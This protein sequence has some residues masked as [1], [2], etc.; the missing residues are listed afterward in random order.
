MVWNIDLLSS[1]LQGSIHL[2]LTYSESTVLF[3]AGCRSN[4]L[5]VLSLH[6]FLHSDLAEITVA[7]GVGQTGFQFYHCTNLCNF[8]DIPGGPVV[9]TAL[10]MQGA[11]VWCLVGRLDPACMLQLSLYPT[12][13]VCTPQ[14]NTPY[15]T[16]KSQCSKNKVNIFNTHQM[17]PTLKKL[18]ATPE[19]QILICKTG[20]LLK[21]NEI[22]YTRLL[23]HSFGKVCGLSR[24]VVSDS[25]DPMYCTPWTVA[26]QA[27]YP[28][29]FPGKTTAVGCYFLLQGIFLTRASNPRSSALQ[30]DS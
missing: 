14:L 23:T 24:S 15:T 4:V 17:C 16:T 28:W 26:R 20:W 13:K 6:F 3:Y 21:L 7:V 2:G 12:I 25:W 22:I 5:F 1:R 10:P 30:A 29:D 19:S 18:S 8:G 27:P 9:N 11:Q